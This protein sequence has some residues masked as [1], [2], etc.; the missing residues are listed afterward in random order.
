MLS[1]RGMQQP[2][3]FK[4]NRILT[5]CCERTESYLLMLTA[6]SLLHFQE[7]GS[8]FVIGEE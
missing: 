3:V 4:I 5:K 1:H 6:L 7:I 2:I 8:L